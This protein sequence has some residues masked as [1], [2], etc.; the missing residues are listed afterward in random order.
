MLRRWRRRRSG[1]R[2]RGCR[3]RCCS[4]RRRRR[5]R[6]GPWCGSRRWRRS[7]CRTRRCCGRW[8]RRRRRRCLGGGGR[9]SGGRRRARRWPLGPAVR[10]SLFLGLG[11]D[12]RCGLR[13]RCGGRELRYRQRCCGKQHDAKV[14][15]DVLGPRKNPGSNEFGFIDAL[16]DSQQVIIRPE[17][18]CLQMARRN[19]FHRANRLHGPL[20]IACSDDGLNAGPRRFPYRSLDSAFVDH[21]VRAP[22]VHPASCLAAPPVAEAGPVRAPAAAPPGADFREVL[23]AGA[24]SACP[25]LPAESP[26]GRSASHRDLAVLADVRPCAGRGG[27]SHFH[28]TDDGAGRIPEFRIVGGD[29]QHANVRILGA[30]PPGFRR[31]R[32]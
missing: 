9:W 15:H 10:A 16:D 24:R 14:C 29:L 5:R 27:C 7:R 12:Q 26:A 1:R 30:V 20:F 28:I 21:S 25:A 31:G 18:G 11:D 2:W 6:C 13:M 4:R 19:L 3:A 32:K 23:P 8:R 17:C 22:A